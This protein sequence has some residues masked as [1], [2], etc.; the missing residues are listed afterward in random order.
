[1]VPL[2]IA[3]WLSF[4]HAH[5]PTTAVPVRAAVTARVGCSAAWIECVAD[6]APPRRSATRRA[7][8]RAARAD[9]DASVRPDDSGYR[10]DALRVT[11]PVT[12][13]VAPR[14]EKRPGHAPPV[15]PLAAGERLASGVTGAA[16]ARARTLRRA[17]AV[18]ARGAVV[19]YFA[20]APPLQA[21]RPSR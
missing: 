5:A 14:G 20:T 4:L 15:A 8:D 7:G 17:H 19:P 11:R 1:M 9:A 2:L 3:L 16:D 12:D 18:A 6:V 10:D 21:D 13:L